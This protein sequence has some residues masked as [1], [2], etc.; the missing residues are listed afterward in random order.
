MNQGTEIATGE[1]MLGTGV[2]SYQGVKAMN[3]PLLVV[4]YIGQSEVSGLTVNPV[5]GRSWQKKQSPGTVVHL[6]V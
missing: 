2:K 6:M 1:T 4:T 3:R 5:T